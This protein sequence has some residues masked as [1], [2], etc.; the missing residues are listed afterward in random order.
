MTDNR[1]PH[2]KKESVNVAIE[3][4]MSTRRAILDV[5][6]ERKEED[7][8]LKST[9]D[10]IDKLEAYAKSLECEQVAQCEKDC[11]QGSKKD[12]AQEVA[13]S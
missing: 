9:S 1:K 3:R 2:R 7:E 8:I 10:V 12:A 6:L 4:M 5:R 13:A 11:K